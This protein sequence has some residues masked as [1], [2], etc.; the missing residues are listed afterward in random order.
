MG[1]SWQCDGLAVR[2]AR[3]GQGR[4]AHRCRLGQ[5]AAA[6]HAWFSLDP[7]DPDD[8]SS[9]YVRYVAISEMRE[10]W[11]CRGVVGS[12]LGGGGCRAGGAVEAWLPRCRR[13]VPRNSQLTTHHSPL[14]PVVSGGVRGGHGGR[15]RNMIVKF[16]IKGTCI[17]QRHGRP[18][19]GGHGADIGVRHGLKGACDGIGVEKDGGGGHGH[20]AGVGCGVSGCMTVHARCSFSYSYLV[21][22]SPL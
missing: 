2:A 12:R 5:C 20:P 21:L 3:L 7:R 14:T 1:S 11:A 13:R 10:G 16:Y 9:G 6:E 22:E 15:V 18:C 19:P 17:R 8:Y 4:Q